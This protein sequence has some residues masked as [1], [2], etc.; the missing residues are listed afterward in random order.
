MTDDTPH[1]AAKRPLT[2]RE[3]TELRSNCVTDSGS[4]VTW[5]AAADR[6]SLFQEHASNAGALVSDW[7][8]E[9]QLPY[10]KGHDRLLLG[11]LT[12]LREGLRKEHRAVW[13][14]VLTLTGEPYQSND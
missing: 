10:N 4:A 11:Q 12:D 13:T 14:H 1:P 6:F 8:A 7:Q 5:N 3:G 9:S 2:V